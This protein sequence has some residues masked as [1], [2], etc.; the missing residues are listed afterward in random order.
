MARS[1][2]TDPELDGLGDTPEGP[3]SP[4]VG[5]AA[6]GSGSGW[7][8]SSNSRIAS[9]ERRTSLAPL[10]TQWRRSCDED[11]ASLAIATATV[12][13]CQSPRLLPRRDASTR[14]SSGWHR[15]RDVSTAATASVVAAVA[16]T[17][18]RSV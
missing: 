17:A 10:I 18:D 12:L 1:S 4:A 8:R 16:A 3:A 14:R 7:P 2:D 5:P 6:V 9:S 15:R 13:P 11:R